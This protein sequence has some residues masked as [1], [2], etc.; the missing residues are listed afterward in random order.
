MKE[1]SPASLKP[2][3]QERMHRG[4]IVPDRL[5]GRPRRVHA[6]GKLTISLCSVVMGEGQPCALIRSESGEPP[7]F[8][9][10]HR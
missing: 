4:K 9:G 5:A 3:V 2:Q 8:T 10:T 1:V 6:T 7:P